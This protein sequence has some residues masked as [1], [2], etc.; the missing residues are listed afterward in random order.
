M[1]LPRVYV[2]AT[3]GA[4]A[5]PPAAPNATGLPTGELDKVLLAHLPEIEN[6]AAV[7][8][9]TFCNMGS[10]DF[11]PDIW[12]RLACRV[13]EILARDD[14][15]GLVIT[16]GTDTIEETAYFLNLT[17]KSEKPVVLVGTMPPAIDGSRNLQNAILL[18]GHPQSR[19]RGV[20]VLLNEQINGAR[21]VT[22]TNTTH[23]ETFKAVD[24]GFLGYC[25]D[26]EPHYYKATTRLHTVHSVFSVTPETILPRVDILYLY[27]GVDR[28][29]VAAAIE[30]GAE[31]IV[32]AGFGHGNI[33]QDLR[34]YLAAISPAVVVVRSSRT[35]TGLVTPHARRP[36]PQIP[37][38]RQSQPPKS[39]H[40]PHARPRPHAQFTNHS[41][42]LRDLLKPMKAIK[43]HLH[44]DAFLL[45]S[46]FVLVPAT[47]I[48]S[49]LEAAYRPL[50]ANYLP[51]FRRNGYR[52]RRNEKPRAGKLAIL[53]LAVPL[54]LVLAG[55]GTGRGSVG[56]V[57]GGRGGNGKKGLAGRAK[58]R[59]MV[60]FLDEKWSFIGVV[61]LEL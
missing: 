60:C 18:A 9:E 17:V 25:Q 28:K 57:A 41:R 56:R 13:N 22:K 34:E 47:D 6:R 54:F 16:H 23:V 15:D 48:Y 10:Y 12:I 30:A 20:L 37:H 40:P 4:M 1:N 44:G 35:G 52:T 31:G 7:S 42:I 3:G 26:G 53:P 11:T 2:I 21:D 32:T 43:K 46:A 5:G 61:L 8:G 58:W 45:C 55:T 24:L 33:G 39:P 27:V 14:I 36:R 50:T 49:F 29:I 38:R 19:G 51:L 59:V